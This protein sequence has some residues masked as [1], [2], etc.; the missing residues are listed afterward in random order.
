VITSPS[1]PPCQESNSGREEGGE[2]DNGG[3][4][5]SMGEPVEEQVVAH[6][7][8]RGD[9][10]G[11]QKMRMETPGRGGGG[12]DVMRNDTRRRSPVT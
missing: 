6:G 8:G 12:G 2:G 7:V 11:G 5:Q 3:A 10:S 1:D 9:L 4:W